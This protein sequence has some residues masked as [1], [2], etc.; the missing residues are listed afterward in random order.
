MKCLSLDGEN[1]TWNSLI[2]KQMPELQALRSLLIVF[3][4]YV[5][6]R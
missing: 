3:K 4:I 5:V 2:M 1:R 6:I